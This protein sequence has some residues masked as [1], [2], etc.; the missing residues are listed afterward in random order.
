MCRWL[1]Y[2]GSPV[3]VES[4]RS[5][6]L[7]EH[8]R[9]VHRVAGPAD[10]LPPVPPRPR[11]VRARRADG[12]LVRRQAGPAD[13]GRSLGVPQHRRLDAACAVSENRQLAV[14]AARV[15]LPQPLGDLRSA[16]RRVLGSTCAGLRNGRDEL[17]P[18]TPTSLVATA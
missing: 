14:V 15:V 13:G 11:A 9:C 10:R 5:S 7:V 8:V 3:L 6:P 16:R 1:A 4:M 2:I 18:F 17:H 12:R